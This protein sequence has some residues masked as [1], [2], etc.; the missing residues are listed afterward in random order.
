M[1]RFFLVTLITKK[2]SVETFV[3]VL[4]VYLFICCEAYLLW[5]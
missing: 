2:I 5:Q 4:V 3:L 1:Q